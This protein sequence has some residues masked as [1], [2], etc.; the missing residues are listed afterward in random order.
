MSFPGMHIDDLSLN[1]LAG[2]RPSFSYDSQYLAIGTSAGVQLYHIPTRQ[3]RTLSTKPTDAAIFSPVTNQIAFNIFTNHNLV[4]NVVR[5]WDY[6][7]NKEISPSGFE[8]S[9]R[10]L[11]WSPDG[12]GILTGRGMERL[13][14]YDTVTSTHRQTDKLLNAWVLTAAISPDGSLLAAI[15]WQ[16][17]VHLSETD[18]LKE[19]GTL[20]SGD[21]HASAL[22]F[23]PDGKLLATGS[24]NQVIQIWDVAGKRLERQ[25]RGHRGRIAGLAFSPDGRVLASTADDGKVML[26]DPLGQSENQIANGIDWPDYHPPQFSSDGK[27]VCLD[28][29][30]GNRFSFLDSASLRETFS[31]ITTNIQEMLSLSPDSKQFVIMTTNP[32][33]ELLVR[34]AETSSNR[35]TIHLNVP[36]KYPYKAQL[37]PDGT[38]IA[39]NSTDHGTLEKILY[40]AATGEQIL[41]FNIQ[42]WF[43]GLSCFLPDGRTYA[44]A[45]GS[46]IDIWDLSSRKKTRTLE[47]NSQV[48]AISISPDGQALAAA[49][50]D[51]SIL[52]WDLKSGATQGALFG[53]AGQ[54]VALTFSPDGRTLASGGEDGMLRFW[55]FATHRELASFRIGAEVGV[56]AFSPDNQMLV[57]GGIGSYRVWRAP[58]SGTAVKTVGSPLSIADLPA[59][60]IWRVPDGDHVGKFN[61][62]EPANKASDP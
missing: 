61:L 25:L 11:G 1:Q 2:Y 42:R 36:D 49:L 10:L 19:I 29:D 5:V 4:E 22:A 38:I 27:L 40:K 14:W 17:T 46:G 57:S 59:N 55:S 33:P 3:T 51:H 16:G 15:D 44:S 30:E 50:E 60:S 26:W 52:M 62:T 39:V 31:V 24:G 12:T 23:S 47:C 54:I 58:R 21:I 18:D 45:Q 37:S 6:E 48:S 34:V 9:G 20:A 13:D 32:T 56:L 53:S 28:M 35:A 43:Y 41:S 7:G 8:G